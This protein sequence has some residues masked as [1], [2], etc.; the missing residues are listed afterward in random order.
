MSEK[1]LRARRRVQ[2]RSEIH[3][4]AV[5]L[6][7]E[8][9]FNEV[10]VDEIA[11]AA[12]VSPRTFFNYFPT[13]QEAIFPGP[14]EL[15][16]ETIEQFVTGAGSLLADLRDLISNYAELAP[17]VR[18]QMVELRPIFAQQPEIWIHLHK[19]FGDLEQ[20][21]A[22]AIAQR[23]HRT[24]PTSDDYVIAAVSTS[25]M[26]SALRCWA[27]LE[28]ADSPTALTDLL[29]RNFTAIKLLAAEE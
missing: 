19:R 25:V 8:R 22:Q 4:A 26:R 5:E 3:D 7:L 6:V 9:G 14:P 21:L 29:D 17:K 15:D 2:T 12:G 16:A 20:Q 18:H 23:R 11:E 1:S 27:R 24:D 13:K 10:T 28:K